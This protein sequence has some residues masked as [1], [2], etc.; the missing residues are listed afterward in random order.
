M[1]NSISGP[2]HL[3]DAKMRQYQWLLRLWQVY[4]KEHPHQR[5]GQ[6]LFNVLDQNLP[7]FARR[8]WGK[9]NDP[10]YEDKNIAACLGDLLA[11]CLFEDLD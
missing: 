2:P 7:V 9:P 8:V 4:M 3:A 6:A 11:Y 10:F 1:G 5:L